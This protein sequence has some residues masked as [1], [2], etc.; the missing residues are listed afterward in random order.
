MG[1]TVDCLSWE[2]FTAYLRQATA[3]KSFEDM[4]RTEAEMAIFAKKVLGDPRRAAEVQ[5][6]CPASL[7][8]MQAKA[9]GAATARQIAD[10]SHSQADLE[11]WLATVADETLASIAAAA[12]AETAKRKKNAKKKR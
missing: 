3:L 9:A 2:A 8:Q 11:V 12:K 1:L 10:P 5:K 4:D 7:A 6:S